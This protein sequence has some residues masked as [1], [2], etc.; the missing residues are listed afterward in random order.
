M[1]ST[2][3]EDDAMA[4]T[5]AATAHA[6]A[7]ES[8]ASPL[9]ENARP[10]FDALARLDCAQLEALF[11]RGRGFAL[12]SLHG[13]PAGRALAVPGWDTGLRGSFVRTLHG[14]ILNPW[15]GKSF[16]AARSATEHAGMN[17][18]RFFGKAFRHARFEFKTYE[19]SSVIDGAPC[20]AIDYDVPGNP[21]LARPIYDELRLI[22]DQLYLGRGMRRTKSGKA[23]LVVWFALDNA[24]PDARVAWSGY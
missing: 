2:S 5:A 6:D 23:K 20:V 11:A 18:L 4:H 1:L 19:T 13:D 12:A 3:P 21:K 7:L 15:E 24:H 9:T 17:R 22:A 14:S 10:S 16:G 8:E